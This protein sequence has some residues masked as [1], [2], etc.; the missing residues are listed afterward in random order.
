LP[1]AGTMCSKYFTERS[2]TIFHRPSR[3]RPRRH[4]LVRGLSRRLHAGRRPGL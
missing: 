2:Q 4:H 3:G 1:E